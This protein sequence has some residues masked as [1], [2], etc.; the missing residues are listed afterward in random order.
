MA[1]YLTAFCGNLHPEY[2]PATAKK[3]VDRLLIEWRAEDPAAPERRHVKDEWGRWVAG[4]H[5]GNR[6]V[7]VFRDDDGIGSTALG[8]EIGHELLEPKGYH[9][10]DKGHTDT[11]FP[12]IQ[13]VDDKW[14]QART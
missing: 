10:D 4:Y 12:L 6:C 11:V 8:H 14:R 5:Q 2:S 3:C 9:D 1:K 13:I 7:V